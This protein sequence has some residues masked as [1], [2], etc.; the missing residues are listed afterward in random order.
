[1]K[2]TE[3]LKVKPGIK[4]GTEQRNNYFLENAGVALFVDADTGV[5]GRGANPNELRLST[6]CNDSN[7]VIDPQLHVHVDKPRGFCNILKVKISYC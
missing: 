2:Q 4:S 3:Y 7:F 6:I 1:M 5:V